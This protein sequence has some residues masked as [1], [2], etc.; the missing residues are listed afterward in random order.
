METILAM[1]N[2]VRWHSEAYKLTHVT[3][4]VWYLEL[5]SSSPRM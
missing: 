1:F 2:A 5:K 3:P 4:E